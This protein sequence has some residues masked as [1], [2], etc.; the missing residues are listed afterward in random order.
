GGR[1]TRLETFEP[2]DI[3]AAL[4]RFAKLRPD[5]LRIPPNAATRVRDRLERAMATLDWDA[6]EALCAPTLEFDDR[7]RLVRTSGGREMFIASARVIGAGRT[8][9]ER[10][11]LATA[12]GRLALEHGGW[13]R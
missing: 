6:Y 1:S 10:T 11:V 5:P 7:R 3:D 9:K 12:G 8:R 2:E 4:A 13:A